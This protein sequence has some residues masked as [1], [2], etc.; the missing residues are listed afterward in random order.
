MR[1]I[2]NIG[3]IHRHYVTVLRKTHADCRRSQASCSQNALPLCTIQTVI[4]SV[5]CLSPRSMTQKC[6]W[7]HLLL[8]TSGLTI[9]PSQLS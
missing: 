9:N 8:I 5:W 7:M 4:S 1:Q 2:R 6:T 3:P